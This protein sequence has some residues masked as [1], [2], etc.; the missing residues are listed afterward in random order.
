M[1]PQPPH[2]HRQL[3]TAL[4]CVHVSC[5]EEEGCG[6]AHPKPLLLRRGMHRVTL[7]LS[8]QHNPS[9]P[10]MRDTRTAYGTQDA[11]R[12]TATLHHTKWDRACGVK[13]PNEGR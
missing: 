12:S 1:E 5:S 2:C 7:R 13:S 6:L 3:H 8:N 4:L 10:T 11:F 9:F